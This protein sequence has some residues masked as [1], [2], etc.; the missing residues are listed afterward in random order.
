MM[1]DNLMRHYTVLK[2]FLEKSLRQ[3][4]AEGKSN[5][6]RD[7]LL[8]LSAVQFE[9]LSTDVYDELMRRKRVDG[10]RGPNGVTEKNVEEF[11]APMRSFHPKRNQARQKLSTLPAPRFSALATD[12]FFELERRFPRFTGAYIERRDSPANSMRGPR[13]RAGTPNGTR[14]ESR[15]RQGARRAHPPRQGSL[16]GQVFAGRGIP[17]LG[18]QDEYSRPTPKSSQSNTIVPNKSYL[19]EDDDDQTGPE[20]NDDTYGMRRRDTGNT[21]KSF[22]SSERDQKMIGEQKSQINDLQGKID[23][24]ES[25]MR[26][27]EAA[28]DRLESGQRESENVSQIVPIPLERY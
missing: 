20:D 2:E 28:V 23:S 26:E 5:R 17:G 6:A 22:G 8:R 7:K 1:E 15:E 19:V 11:L 12:V 9:E 14:P 16:G 10:Q 25:Q 4:Q 13:S 21:N 24:F 27:K 18:S 3:D